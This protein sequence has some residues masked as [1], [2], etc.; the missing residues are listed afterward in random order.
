MEFSQS[1][2]ELLQLENEI[3]SQINICDLV[4]AFIEKDFKNFLENISPQ[5]PMIFEGSILNEVINFTNSNRHHGKFNLE[6]NKF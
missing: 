3:H 5:N 4:R 6:P 2:T 1:E